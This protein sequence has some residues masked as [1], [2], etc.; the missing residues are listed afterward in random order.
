MGQALDR[1]LTHSTDGIYLYA[2]S[3]SAGF[4]ITVSLTTAQAIR[5]SKVI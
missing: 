4:P 5:T 3:S 2:V 1:S